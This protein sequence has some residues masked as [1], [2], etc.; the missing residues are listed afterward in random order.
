MGGVGIG[1]RVG[2]VRIGG[3]VGGVRT[4]GRMGRLFEWAGRGGRVCG[5]HNLRMFSWRHDNVI[6][7]WKMHLD[8]D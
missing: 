2:G 8:W 6:D 4:G 3:K 1:G 7:L 5:R